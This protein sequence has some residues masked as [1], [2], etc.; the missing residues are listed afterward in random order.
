MTFYL[1]P[2]PALQHVAYSRLSCIGCVKLCEITTSSTGFFLLH[3][4]RNLPA[5]FTFFCRHVV[6]RDSE[7]RVCRAD[8]A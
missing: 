1:L 8:V 6:S 7:H 5:K 3:A 2:P 4:N